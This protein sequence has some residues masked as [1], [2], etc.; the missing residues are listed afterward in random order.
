MKHV[1]SFITTVLI[2]F[3]AAD[4]A[5]S[6]SLLI[7]EI[8]PGTSGN[9]WVELYFHSAERERINIS[10]FYVTMY[11]GSNEPLSAFPV[12]LY[13]YDRPETPYDDRFAEIYLTEASTPD[14]TELTGDT[15]RN[16]RID[17]Y[18]GNYGSSLWNS[19]CVVAI[20]TDDD[21]SNGGIIDFA[22]F[23]NR[24]GSPNSTIESYVKHAQTHHHWEGYSGESG[25]T[26]GGKLVSPSPANHSSDHWNESMLLALGPGIRAGEV[27]AGLENIAPTVLHALRVEPAP[28]YDGKVLPIF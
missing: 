14:E 20:D 22:A 13:S 5:F 9:D 17:L 23:S 7:N 3:A 6:G 12:T 1:F 15:N 28:D 24:D 10:S 2:L 25:I 4:S 19:D 8:A 18:C 26:G 21:P 27:Q 16:G 11:Y